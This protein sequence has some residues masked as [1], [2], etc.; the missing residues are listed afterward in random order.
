MGLHDLRRRPPQGHH[1]LK[2]LILEAAIM[3]GEFLEDYAACVPADS[4]DGRHVIAR[5][6]PPRRS[7]A[8]RDEE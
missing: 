8:Q 5:E 7:K 6:R 3:I 1:A 4:D 2:R